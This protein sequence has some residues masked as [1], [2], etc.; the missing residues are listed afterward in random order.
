MFNYK[1][2]QF[3]R[4]QSLQNPTDPA[5]GQNRAEQVQVRSMSYLEKTMKKVGKHSKIK[6]SDLPTPTPEASLSV[7]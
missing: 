6:A 3:L 1:V 7:T 4:E 2:G 5:Y